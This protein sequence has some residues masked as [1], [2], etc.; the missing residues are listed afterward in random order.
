M[1]TTKTS[2]IQ[3][4]CIIT[5][6]R[7]G[8][9]QWKVLR[10]FLPKCEPPTNIEK[11]SRESPPFYGSY[12]Q[13]THL[14]FFITSKNPVKISSLEETGRKTIQQILFPSYFQEVLSLNCKLFYYSYPK[15]SIQW[16]KAL[17]KQDFLLSFIMEIAIREALFHCQKWKFF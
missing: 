10:S 5:H 4:K 11:K 6:V 1:Q 13:G 12:K 17:N 9:L 15:F 8:K 2:Q 7:R 14:D 16:Q 3:V